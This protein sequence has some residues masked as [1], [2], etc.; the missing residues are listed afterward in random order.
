MIHVSSVGTKA[1]HAEEAKGHSK[2]PRALPCTTETDGCYRV[3]SLFVVVVAERIKCMSRAGV[4][5]QVPHN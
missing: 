4:P 3:W 1:D 5:A 2:D